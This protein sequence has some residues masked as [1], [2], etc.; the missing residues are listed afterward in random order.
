MCDASV[1]RTVAPVIDDGLISSLNVIV[2]ATVGAASVC[3]FD[4][5]VTATV[6]EV[7]SVHGA[8][9]ENRTSTQ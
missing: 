4:G 1:S 8:D 5:A 9:G 6:G 3:P 7:E 2:G